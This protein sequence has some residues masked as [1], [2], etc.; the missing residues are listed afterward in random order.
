ML[1]NGQ[2]RGRKKGASEAGRKIMRGEKE[3]ERE[4]EKNDEGEGKGGRRR[5]DIERTIAN[6]IKIYSA[7]YIPP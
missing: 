6:Y 5:R 3:K 7:G 4:K 1:Q 2:E